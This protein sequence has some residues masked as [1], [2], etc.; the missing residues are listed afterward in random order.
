MIWDDAQ[1]SRWKH[2]T[3]VSRFNEFELDQG[4]KIV[5]KW[6]NIEVSREATIIFL[7]KGWTRYYVLLIKLKLKLI[8]RG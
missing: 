2:D 3:L 6:Q 4:Q 5:I 7:F 8:A 1:S